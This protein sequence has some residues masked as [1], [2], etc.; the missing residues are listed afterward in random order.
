[1]SEQAPEERQR[2]LLVL[3][4]PEE[5]EGVEADSRQ[6]LAATRMGSIKSIITNLQVG[7]SGVLAGAGPGFQGC[8]PLPACVP[9]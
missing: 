1:M 3:G 7:A 9:A 2:P 6:Q 5:G 4:Q 8:M